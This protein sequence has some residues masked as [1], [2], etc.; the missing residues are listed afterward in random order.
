MKKKITLRQLALTRQGPSGSVVG[1][2]DRWLEITHRCEDPPLRSMWIRLCLH[3]LHYDFRMLA[4][5]EDF[6]NFE[7]MIRYMETIESRILLP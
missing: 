5:G 3:S 7:E 1:Y 2:I 6:R 4:I